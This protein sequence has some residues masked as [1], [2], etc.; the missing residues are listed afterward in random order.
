MVASTGSSFVFKKAIQSS[1][2]SNSLNHPRFPAVH[3]CLGHARVLI[4]EV[5]H[6]WEPNERT[7]FLIARRCDIISRKLETMEYNTFSLLLIWSI[8]LTGSSRQTGFTRYVLIGRRSIG[9]NGAL[10][11]TQAVRAE[12]MSPDDQVCPDS[13]DWIPAC[14]YGLHHHSSLFISPNL[15]MILWPAPPGDVRL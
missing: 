7:I 4:S 1:K 15:I 8:C 9:G 6:R 5:E 2:S 12:N 11:R 14:L 13:S 3:R 10:A